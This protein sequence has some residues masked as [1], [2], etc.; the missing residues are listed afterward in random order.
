[1]S[2]RMCIKLC[3]LYDLASNVAEAVNAATEHPEI[4][5]RLS[6]SAQRIREQ[7]QAIHPQP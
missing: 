3:F 1:M 5:T 7:T 4:V 2:L 6:E